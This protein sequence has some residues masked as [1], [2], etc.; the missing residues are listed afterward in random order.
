MQKSILIPFVSA[1]N[2]A[3]K[4]NELLSKHH[5]SEDLPVPIE[6]IV[7]LRLGIRVI[8]LKGLKDY[9]GV[10]SYLS[11]SANSNS[12]AI[13][14]YCY[15]NFEERTRFTYAHELGHLVLHKE[16]YESQNIRDLADF[17]NFQ[18]ALSADNIK[19]LELQ[20]HI[21][22][23]YVLMPQNRFGLCVDKMVR[24]VGGMGS[25][26]I[27]DAETILRSLVDKFAVSPEAALR[28]LKYERS[29]L[30]KELLKSSV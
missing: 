26:S 5:P 9:L 20:A 21:F 1:R 22:A 18:N 13:D 6:E 24:G 29:E 14:E 8:P 30:V 7:E 27:K 10:D 16:I 15:E 19:R 25:I 3:T 11:L 23:G 28:Q 12:I 2:L 17:K 4:A